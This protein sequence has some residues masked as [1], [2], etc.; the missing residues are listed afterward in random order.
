MPT[1]STSPGPIR[2]TDIVE[3][4][5]AYE[6]VDPIDLDPVSSVVDLDAIERLFSKAGQSPDS[7]GGYASFTFNSYEVVVYS[8][9]RVQVDG[10]YPL[11]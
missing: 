8:D 5:A 11:E 3:A 10:E 2:A 9:G 4:I 6:N 1:N 7:N